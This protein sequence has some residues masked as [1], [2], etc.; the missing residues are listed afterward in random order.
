MDG[1]IVKQRGVDEAHKVI[2]DVDSKDMVLNIK[3]NIQRFT[4]EDVGLVFF[5]AS[6]KKL[7][8][9]TSVELYVS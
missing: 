1:E 8:F 3:R 6:S 4:E 7:C 9:Q 2:Q 5:T